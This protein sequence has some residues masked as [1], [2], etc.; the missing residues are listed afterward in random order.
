MFAY[1]LEYL[2][3]SFCI[4]IHRHAEKHVP[5][6]S[7]FNCESEYLLHLLKSWYYNVLINLAEVDK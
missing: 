4:A 7:A 2:Q 1:F 6:L 5:T 3:R